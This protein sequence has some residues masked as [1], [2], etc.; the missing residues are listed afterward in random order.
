MLPAPWLDGR[1]NSVKS[2]CYGLAIYTKPNQGM[3]TR[4]FSIRTIQTPVI[5][6]RA[7]LLSPLIR[8]PKRG[9]R[10]YRKR[11][12][13]REKENNVLIFIEKKQENNFCIV[14]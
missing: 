5:G 12:A 9:T 8:L 2:P 1:P 10:F 3:T 11:Y 14:K 7:A 6:I 13:N 4:G